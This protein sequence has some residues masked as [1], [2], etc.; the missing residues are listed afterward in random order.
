M[1]DNMINIR[2]DVALMSF[3]IPGTQD[4]LQGADLCRMQLISVKPAI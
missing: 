4:Y 1:L 3:I 2:S